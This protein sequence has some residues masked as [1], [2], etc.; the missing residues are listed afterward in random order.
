MAY[1]GTCDSWTNGTASYSGAR[2]TTAGGVGSG[3]D[4]NLSRP[5]ACCR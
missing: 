5:I 1:S 3:Y 2:V 4:C